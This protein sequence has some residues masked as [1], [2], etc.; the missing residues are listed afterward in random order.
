VTPLRVSQR[1]HLEI[2]DVTWEE[3]GNSVVLSYDFGKYL[4]LFKAN[5]D[6][7]YVILWVD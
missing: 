5:I 1:T 7:D 2:N 6:F 3:G 4:C